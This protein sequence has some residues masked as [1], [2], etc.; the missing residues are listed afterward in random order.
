MATRSNM[1]DS[2][3]DM[4][5]TLTKFLNGP[6]TI[7][8]PMVGN[9]VAK[10]RTLLPD[11]NHDPAAHLPL[12]DAPAGLDDIAKPDLGGHRRDLVPRQIT[13]Q[14]VP[15]QL[16]QRQRAHHRIDAEQ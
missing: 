1:G 16:P 8:T 9:F 15:C 4:R 3:I 7:L 5:A 11:L 2:T 10:T 13:L 14:P 6:L 12:D